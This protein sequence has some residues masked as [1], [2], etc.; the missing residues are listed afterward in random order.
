MS[1]NQDYDE[2]WDRF[3]ELKYGDDGA[4]KI[5]SGCG[6]GFITLWVLVIALSL[7]TT[8]LVVYALYLLFLWLRLQVGA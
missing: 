3:E 6:C 8:G 1:K 5:A 2:Y 7:V 4:S